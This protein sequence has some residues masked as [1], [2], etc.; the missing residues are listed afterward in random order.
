MIKAKISGF[1]DEA[2]FDL[3]EQI[4]II[5]VLGE[6][7]LCPRKIGK[8]AITELTFEEFKESIYPKLKENNIKFSSIGSSLGK[9]NIN[10]EQGYQKQLLQLQELIRICKLMDCKYIRIFSFF[11]AIDEPEKYFEQVVAKLKGFLDI[12][13]GSGVILLHENEKK[14]YG[15]IPER[16]LSLYNALK[17]DGLQLVYDASNFIQCDTDPL[18]AYNQLKEYVVYYHI[19]DCDKRSKIEVPVGLGDGAYSEIFDDLAKRNYTGFMTLEPH[20]AKYAL[21]K[22]PVYLISWIGG[23]KIKKIA[24]TFRNIDT[25]LGKSSF[26]KVSRRDVFLAQYYGLV[27]LISEVNKNEEKN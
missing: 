20:T 10:D 12:A 5:K 24:Q 18:Q 4:N 22:I 26:Q 19:K 15:D 21:L 8:K 1:Y 27:N 11:G 25:Y 9:I 2:S 3:D 17:D 14:V 13:K 16:V 7:Y 23:G 6:E